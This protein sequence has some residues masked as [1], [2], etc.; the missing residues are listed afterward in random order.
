L[1]HLDRLAT[2]REISKEMTPSS[3]SAANSLLIETPPP[4]MTVP[5]AVTAYFGYDLIIYD[6]LDETERR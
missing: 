2:G 6:S 1:L 4:H 3:R 5:V